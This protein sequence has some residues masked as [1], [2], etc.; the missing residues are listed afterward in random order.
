MDKRLSRDSVELLRVEVLHTRPDGTPADPTIYPVAVAV[1]PADVRY[2][3]STDFKPAQWQHGPAGPVAV[4]LVGTG[5]DVGTLALGRN[6]VWVRVQADPEI[7][8]MRADMT[9]VV[10]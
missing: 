2:V 10:Y 4:V 1:T 7:P 9:L 6:A 5:S 8:V 3:L